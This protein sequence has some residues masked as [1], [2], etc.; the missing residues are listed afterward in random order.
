MNIFPYYRDFFQKNERLLKV[1]TW[2]LMKIKQIPIFYDENWKS[3]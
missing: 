2:T 1:T 3:Y